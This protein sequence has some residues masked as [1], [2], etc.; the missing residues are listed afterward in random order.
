MIVDYLILSSTVV[1]RFRCDSQLSI[2]RFTRVSDRKDQYGG[3]KATDT[4]RLK[5]LETGNKRLKNIGAGRALEIAIL[6]E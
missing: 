6:N 2:V 5:K 4:K 1:K 3:I